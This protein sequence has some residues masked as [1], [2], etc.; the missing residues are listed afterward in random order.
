MSEKRYYEKD[1]D[2]LYYIFDSETLS[3]KEFEKKIEYDE[4]SVFADSL[5]SKEILD[6][7]NENEELK[8]ENEELKQEKKK[9]LDTINNKITEKG[10]NWY[11]AE[12]NSKEEKKANLQ[13]KVLEE[14]KEEI[15]KTM[16]E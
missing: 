14:V 16:E 4:Y 6:L 10:M 3:E 7:L 12:D 5:T 11:R 1:Y 8:R 2:E 13:L 9:I 15:I